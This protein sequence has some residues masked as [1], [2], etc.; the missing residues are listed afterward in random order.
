LE[1]RTICHFPFRVYFEK[2]RDG[3]DASFSYIKEHENRPCAFRGAQSRLKMNPLMSILNGK[4][5][6]SYL[7]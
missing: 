5:R 1:K 3:T 4:I 7:R 2:L 6:K